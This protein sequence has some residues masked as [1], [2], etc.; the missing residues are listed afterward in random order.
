M[1]GGILYEDIDGQAL[2]DRICSLMDW[3]SNNLLV[4]NYN[5]FA[6]CY[7]NWCP[8]IALPAIEEVCFF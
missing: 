8:D 2:V 7:Q 1:N 4:I 3:K 5:D 6:N